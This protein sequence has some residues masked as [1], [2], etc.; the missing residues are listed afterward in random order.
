MQSKIS[1]KMSAFLDDHVLHIIWAVNA[2]Y[3]GES[4]DI[5][6]DNKLLQGGARFYNKLV[7]K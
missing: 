3:I 1:W 2:V 7:L 6:R 4:L 5:D